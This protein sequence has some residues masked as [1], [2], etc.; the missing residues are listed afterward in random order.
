MFISRDQGSKSLSSHVCEKTDLQIFLYFLVWLIFCDN[1]VKET[2]K[3][4]K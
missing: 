4:T 1:L 3:A 2:K